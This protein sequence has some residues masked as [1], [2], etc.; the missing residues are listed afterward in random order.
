MKYYDNMSMEEY[1]DSYLTGSLPDDEMK[2]FEFMLLD[3]EKLSK[4]FDVRLEAH[5]AAR[6]AFNKWEQSQN[7]EISKSEKSMIPSEKLMELSKMIANLTKQENQNPLEIIIPGLK[8]VFSVDSIFD[9]PKVFSIF[10]DTLPKTERTLCEE[11]DKGSKSDIAAANIGV[12]PSGGL[13]LSQD[14]VLRFLVVFGK[15]QRH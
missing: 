6:Q 2:N 15:V 14:I 8:S 11:F 9:C 3:D 5:K 13:M 4:E 1:I 7:K 12:S 10:F